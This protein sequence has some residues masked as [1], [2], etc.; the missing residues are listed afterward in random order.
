M[1]ISD[2]SSDVCSSDLAAWAVPGDVVGA[3]AIEVP[4]EGKVLAVE[5]EGTGR[6]RGRRAVPAHVRRRARAVPDDLVAGGAVEVGSDRQVG[7]GR[8][9]GAG[10][11]HPALAR[12]EEHPS[13]TPV[14]NAHLV[15]RLLLEK[16]KKN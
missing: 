11:E 16:K 4:D 7:A 12:S 3:V 6:V 9:G 1:R 13:E 8:A 15:C 10:G 5:L 2:W 14:T